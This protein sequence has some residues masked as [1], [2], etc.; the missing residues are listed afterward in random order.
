ML[1]AHKVDRISPVE[2]VVH[3]E[4]QAA[5]VIWRLNRVV[6]VD[7][8]VR[9]KDFCGRGN[10]VTRVKKSAYTFDPAT[11]LDPPARLRVASPDRRLVTNTLL[12][13]CLR[14]AWGLRTR[15]R[16]CTMHGRNM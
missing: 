6:R 7:R 2:L 1:V 15:R 16:S 9:E 4:P 10:G 5:E 14:I 12:V 11:L 3:D 13:P 8:R